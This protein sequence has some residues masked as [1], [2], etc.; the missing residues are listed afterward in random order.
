MV[1]NL[2]KGGKV[3]NK[4]S[5]RDKYNREILIELLNKHG[6]MNKAA[7]NEG[8]NHVTFK[9]LCYSYNIKKKDYNWIN[10]RIGK[11]A[12]NSGTMP[13]KICEFCNKEYKAYR[14][15]MKF[16]STDCFAEH[17][18][19]FYKGEKFAGKN[20]PNYG[21]GEK[22][23][24][25]H[26]NGR[27]LNRDLTNVYSSGYK[28]WYKGIL[29]KSIMESEFAKE[30][31]ELG[32]I[33]DYEPIAFRLKNGTHYTPDFFVMSENKYYE[34]KGR[35]FP[36]SKIK[37]ETFLKEFPDINIEVKGA[38]WWNGR[39]KVLRKLKCVPGNYR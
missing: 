19:I 38:E 36:K 35:W 3:L 39:L 26:K 22:V 21:N 20:N 15:T 27:Y 13:V 10:P 37:F 1:G 12:W 28:T 11:P 16:C 29:F 8:I 7:D 14:P 33:W 34:V 32:L 18:K 5:W 24:Q 25:H 6:D 2:I 9:K 30:L 4:V 17:C 31:D 23:R